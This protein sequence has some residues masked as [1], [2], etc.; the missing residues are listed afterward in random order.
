M[1]RPKKTDHKK[2]HNFTLSDQAKEIL[3][4]MARDRGCSTSAL[5]EMYA[6]SNA[7]KYTH[8][9]ED[10]IPGQMSMDDV[11]AVSDSTPNK[12]KK[13]RGFDKLTAEELEGIDIFSLPGVY[14]EEFEK[15]YGKERAAV[16]ME[17]IANDPIT[18]K[19]LSM[20][21]P[22]KDQEE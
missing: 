20:A 21:I 9:K 6:M 22:S 14:P 19:I 11:P 12:P 2:K 7:D 8:K 17:E 1:G 5:I 4:L 3:D 13:A 15:V 18:Q 10:Q 16:M